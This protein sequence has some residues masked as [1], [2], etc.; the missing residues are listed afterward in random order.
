MILSQSQEILLPSKKEK[1][2]VK[3]KVNDSAVNVESFK[4]SDRYIRRWF[5]AFYLAQVDSR[6]KER[7]EKIERMGKKS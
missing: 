2:F 1:I 3:D 7:I 5:F 4:L 6:V